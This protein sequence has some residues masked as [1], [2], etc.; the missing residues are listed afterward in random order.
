[1]ILVS[2]T[3][4]SGTSVW[5]HVLATAGLPVIGDRFPEGT[6]ALRA[7]N[8]DGFFESQLV[9]GIN[10]QTNPHPTTGAYL[11]PEATRHHAV[12]VFIDGLVRSDVAFL[13]RVL[14]T[15]RP[16]RVFVRSMRRMDALV[17][18]D[19]ATRLPPA[20]SWW[21]SNYAMI[22]D[23][24][25]RGYPV[26]VVSYDAL[27]R[28][29]VA[30]VGEVL[31]WLDV[32]GLAAPSVAAAVVASPDRGEP[33]GPDDDDALAPGIPPGCRATFDALYAAIDEGREVTDRLIAD[34]NRTDAALREMVLQH[35]AAISA[36]TTAQFLP[37]V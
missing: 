35:Q 11:A 13:D 10:F 6:Q 33:D 22:R 23:V 17:G 36:A 19:T 30:R 4:R 20:L 31:D 15:V 29:P 2:G 7:A 37:G 21:C 5:M 9:A 24:A 27:R 28:D 8:P 32:P 18:A 3:K 16:W 12:K 26:H 1:M 34:L 25:V 14:V